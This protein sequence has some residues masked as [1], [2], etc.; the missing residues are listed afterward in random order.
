MT[1]MT[2]RGI[3]EVTLNALK[4]KAQQEGSSVNATILKLLKKELGT[5]KKKRIVE[6]T[7]LDH[8]AGTWSDKDYTEFLKK[9][10]D[11]T[12]IDENIWR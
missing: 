5:A 2:I 3:D 6:H 11:F 12:K 1:T 4:N 10:A 7:D 8:L 9:T